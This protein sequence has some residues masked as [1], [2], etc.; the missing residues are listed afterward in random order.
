MRSEN[1]VYANLKCGCYKFSVDKTAVIEI[2]PRVKLQRTHLGAVCI[3][4]E[5][6]STVSFREASCHSFHKVWTVINGS[7]FRICSSTSS[8]FHYLQ[9]NNDSGPSVSRVK[10]SLSLRTDGFVDNA[11]M[12]TFSSFIFISSPS[13]HSSSLALSSSLL[14]SPCCV[15]SHFCLLPGSPYSHNCAFHV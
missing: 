13:S 1:C 3:Q 6:A 7:W 4:L 15:L 8:S 10:T 11:G 14:S 9:F 2:L 5:Y 12:E